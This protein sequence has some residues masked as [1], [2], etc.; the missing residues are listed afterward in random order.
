MFFSF[1]GTDGVG[2]STQ[3]ELFRQWLL[4]SGH[5]VLL[6]RDPGSTA[7]GERLRELLL[8]KHDIAIDLRSEMFL[9]MT[10][11]TQMVEEVIKPALKAGKTVICDRYLLANIVYQGHAGGLEADMIRQVGAVATDAILPDLTILLDMDVTHARDRMDR[12]LDRIESQGL[13]YMEQVRQGF[14]KESALF[15]ESIKVVNAAREVDEIHQEIVELAK[16][17]LGSAG[18]G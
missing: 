9:Y 16:Q 3:I 7:L 13:V 5:D 2:K 6:C 14:L 1:D 17:F 11:R 18:G 15:P 12:E 10:A 8:Q 4:D